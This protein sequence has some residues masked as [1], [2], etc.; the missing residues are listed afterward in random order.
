MV[1][2]VERLGVYVYVCIVLED[3]G[4]KI[5]PQQNEKKML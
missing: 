5:I 1:I 4:G 2:T 3:E